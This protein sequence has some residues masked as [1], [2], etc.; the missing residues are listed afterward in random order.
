[1]AVE[2]QRMRFSIVDIT[3]TIA[4]ESLDEDSVGIPM[5]VTS[6]LPIQVRSSE[7]KSTESSFTYEDGRGGT[8]DPIDSRRSQMIERL[9]KGYGVDLPTA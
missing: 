8:G 5:L 4:A 1:M 6:S 7:R 2:S 9:L 3:S